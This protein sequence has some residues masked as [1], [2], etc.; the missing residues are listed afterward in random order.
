MSESTRNRPQELEK[1]IHDRRH[2]LEVDVAAVINR[3]RAEEAKATIEITTKVASLGHTAEANKKALVRSRDDGLKQTDKERDLAR[4]QAQSA[5]DRKI[6]A[7]KED[8]ERDRDN[9]NHQLVVDSSALGEQLVA[10]K[11]AIAVA[12]REKVQNLH[13]TYDQEVAPW[14]AEIDAFT[15]RM[16]E[17]AEKLRSQADKVEVA[18]AVGMEPA[19]AATE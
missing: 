15:K 13:G 4:R 7:V 14:K 8:Y 19:P 9:V 17:S 6:T 3:G 16:T 5:Y 1:L 10:R 12:A 11:L 2:K 18:A